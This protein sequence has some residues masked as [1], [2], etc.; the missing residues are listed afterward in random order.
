MTDGQRDDAIENVIVTL[1]Y[2]ELYA[3]EGLAVFVETVRQ[4]HIVELANII[5]ERVTK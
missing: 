1:R 3:E 4:T 2:R 5:V